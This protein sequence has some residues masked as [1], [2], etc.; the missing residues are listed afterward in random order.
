MERPRP[1]ITAAAL[2]LQWTIGGKREIRKLEEHLREGEQVIELVQGTFTQNQ[3]I[4]AL[5]DQRLLFLFHGIVNKRTEEFSVESITA[6]E[7]AKTLNTGTLRLRMS[8]NSCEITQVISADLDRMANAIRTR[9]SKPTG[10]AVPP[11]ED[12][13]ALI[14]G[15]GELRA[16]GAAV[17]A[18]V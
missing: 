10:A 5:T 15:L 17:R 9:I 6:V 12:P 16:A 3:G 11:A 14:K 13:I 7:V 2:R 1:D 18:R 4:V 8:G